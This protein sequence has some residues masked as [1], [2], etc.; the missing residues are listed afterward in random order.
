MI[1]QERAIRRRQPFLE[2]LEAGFVEVRRFF[3]HLPAHEG[4]ILLGKL[5]RE[6]IEDVR[7]ARGPRGVAVCSETGGSACMDYIIGV[8]IG[9]THIQLTSLPSVTDGPVWAWML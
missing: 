4:V 9:G 6:A 8:D 5:S 2:G 3:N 1:D 7:Q